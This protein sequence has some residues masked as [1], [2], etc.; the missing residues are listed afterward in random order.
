MQEPLRKIQ[1]FST[2][3]TEQYAPALDPAAQDIIRRIQGPTGRMYELIRGLPAYSRLNTEK[4]LFRPVPLDQ[5]LNEVLGDLETAINDRQATVGVGPMPTIQGNAIQLRQL[6]QNL[7]S[8]GLK[9]TPS[10]WIPAVQISASPLSPREMQ[11]L[12]PGAEGNYLVIS[13]QDNGTGFE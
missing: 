7:L 13:V 12:Y 8:N 9:L 3:L 10:D 11:T 1:A 4:P 5:L 2:T 6:F